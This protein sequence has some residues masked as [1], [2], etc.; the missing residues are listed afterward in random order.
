MYLYLLPTYVF[1][2]FSSQVKTVKPNS[3]AS[4]AGLQD[5][6]FILRINGQIV[7]HMTPKDVERI[8]SDSGF[9]LH[10]DIER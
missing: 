8:I 1:I 5:S 4:E 6:D 3:G 7:F 9:I 2:T 10:L